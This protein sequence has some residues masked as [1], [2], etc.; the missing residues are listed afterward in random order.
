MTVWREWIRRGAAV[1]LGAALLGV[2]PLCGAQ[3]SR[4]DAWWTGPMLAPS[5]ATLPQGH[6]LIEPYLYDVLSAGHFDE[7][8]TRRSGPSEHDLGS[9]TYVLYGLTDR[10]TV[11]MI[12]RFAYNMPADAPHSAAPGIGDLTLQL[13]YGLTSYQD[14]RRMPAIAVVLDETL[15]TGRYDRLGRASDGFGAGAYTTGLSLYTQDYL[16]MPNGRILRV[17]LDLTYS[18][19][20][21]V[22]VH[23][24]SVYGTPAGFAGRAYPGDSYSIDAAAEYSMTRNW[25]VA[26]DVVYLHS[27]NTRVR[28]ALAPLGEPLSADSGSSYQVALAPALEYNFSAKVGALLGVRVFPAGRNASA[29]ITPALALNMVF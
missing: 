20:A 10:V 16:W 11:G 28:G 5:G 24:A 21:A 23:D 18:V 29:S 8:G 12:P 22:G 2:A 6:A 9:L 3:Q 1:A 19:S 26:L 25:V 13:G 17:R 27:D 4:A 7:S 15:P 14:G